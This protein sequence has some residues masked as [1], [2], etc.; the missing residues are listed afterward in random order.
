M[1]ASKLVFAFWLVNYWRFRL[2]LSVSVVVNLELLSLPGGVALWERWVRKLFIQDLIQWHSFRFSLVVFR[3]Q[4]SLRGLELLL[5]LKWEKL[6]C[7]SVVRRIQTALNQEFLI[8]IALCGAYNAVLL[9]CR[10]LV[11]LRILSRFLGSVCNFDLCFGII[12]ILL[13]ASHIVW[14]TCI[15]KDCLLIWRSKNSFLFCRCKCVLT[16]INWW[17]TASWEI[18][19]GPNLLPWIYRILFT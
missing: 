5:L 16:L 1:E 18:Y 14:I 10:L 13:I 2:I 3:R 19:W 4:G 9:S 11:K 15:N 8:L 6:T 12:L 7:R 17:R